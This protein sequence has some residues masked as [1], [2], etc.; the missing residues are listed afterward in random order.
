VRRRD[1][2]GSVLLL[3][4]GLSAVLLLLVAVVVD[5]SYVVLAKRALVN[6]AD[7]AAIAAAQQPDRV[8]IGASPAALDERVPLDGA[9]VDDVVAAYEADVTAQQPGL[10]LRPHLEGAGGTV[11][12]VEAFRTVRL[13]FTGWLGVVSVE[14]HAVGRARSPTTP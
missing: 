9:A 8:A 12:V 3:T 14:L 5:V 1:D 2:E 13:P 10:A 11:A 7:G 4:I 6:A